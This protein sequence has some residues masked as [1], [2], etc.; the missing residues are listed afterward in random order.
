METEVYLAKGDVTDEIV[1]GS[2]VVCL[3]GDQRRNTSR[4]GTIFKAG[5]RLLLIR[6][7]VFFSPPNSS[8]PPPIT[9]TAVLMT[10]DLNPWNKT[11]SPQKKLLIVLFA[12]VIIFTYS[13]V[14]VL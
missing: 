6:R 7:I 4:R 14:M 12:F 9:S 2:G 3:L 11:T 10:R 1:E 5:I 13:V 8:F